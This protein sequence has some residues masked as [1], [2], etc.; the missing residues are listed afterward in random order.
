MRIDDRTVGVPAEAAGHLVMAAS[1]AGKYAGLNDEGATSAHLPDLATEIGATPVKRFVDGAA[2]IQVGVLDEL[3]EL[4]EVSGA[5]LARHG[6]ITSPP[7][8]RIPPHQARG[9]LF[10]PD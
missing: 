2:E 4:V 8:T 9:N 10:W 6:S 5:A 1:Q 3:A 7:G